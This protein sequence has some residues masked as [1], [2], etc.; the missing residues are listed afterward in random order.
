MEW[1]I[2]ERKRENEYSFTCHMEK[3]KN[4]FVLFYFKFQESLLWD[5]GWKNHA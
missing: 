3:K 4:A 2:K 1:K 5:L